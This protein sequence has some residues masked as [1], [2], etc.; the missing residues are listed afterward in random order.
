MDNSGLTPATVQGFPIEIPAYE[1]VPW[2]A[3]EPGED[4]PLSQIHILIPIPQLNATFILRLKSAKA[5]DDMIAALS[6]HREEVWGSK[7]P[8]EISFVNEGAA[9]TRKS[10]EGAM[11]GFGVAEEDWDRL[12]A[13]GIRIAGMKIT[14]A[15]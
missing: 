11:L 12:L 7:T 10:A 1:V 9:I 3:G 4:V 14:I 13:F 5:A 8:N 2:S 15:K 6:K